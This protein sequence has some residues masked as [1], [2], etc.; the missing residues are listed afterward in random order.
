MNV[1]VVLAT[2]ILGEDRLSHITGVFHD[3]ANADALV[4]SIIA[5]S[6]LAPGWFDTE[7]TVVEVPM[8]KWGKWQ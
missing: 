6:K 3:K 4:E 7:Y 5:A 8:N 2:E 1:Y